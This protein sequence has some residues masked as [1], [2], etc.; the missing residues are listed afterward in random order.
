M[1]DSIDGIVK[2]AKKFK[3]AKFRFYLHPL[4]PIIL[5]NYKGSAL[6]GGFGC[7]FKKV[8]CIDYN[9]SCERCV[10][11][12]KCAYAY[13]FETP[14]PQNLEE[15]T[16]FKIAYPPHPY[17]LE[18]PF[19]S[20]VIFNPD[21][22]FTFNLILIGKGIEYLPYFISV[23]E[24]LGKSGLGKGRGRYKL[25][26]IENIKG[27]TIYRYGQLENKINQIDFQDIF[28]QYHGVEFNNYSQITIHF[29]TPT[30]IIVGEKLVQE[31]NFKIFLTNL[32]RRISLLSV[33]HGSEKLVFDYLNLLQDA[34]M[35][36]TTEKH[37]RWC[38]WERYSSKQERRM[39]LGGFLGNISFGGELKR[40]LPFIKLGEYIHIGKLTSFGFGKY[41]I[42]E[43][44]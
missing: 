10:L 21:H 7:L 40:F 44:V 29:L 42:V 3:F 26:R 1:K 15:K 16:K 11:K 2:N 39:K 36:T 8:V 35:I 19:N 22:E 23:F 12:N 5:S 9:R 43:E 41:E 14:F 38:D 30:R 31:V 20:Q 25:V 24:E 17:I 4:E 28:N 27:E 6:R 18:P 13:I 32:V 33:F 37:F 34:D